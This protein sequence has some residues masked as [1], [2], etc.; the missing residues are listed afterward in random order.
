L[1]KQ[2]FFSIAEQVFAKNGL[3]DYW[4]NETKDKF[5]A[6]CNIILEQ[7]KVMN[8]SAIRDEEGVICRH[9]AD[10]LTVAKHI[11]AGASVLDVGSGGGI[12]QA[13]V[14]GSNGGGG[15]SYTSYSGM[16]APE[17]PEVPE[18]L[19]WFMASRYVCA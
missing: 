14:G 9:F 6:L 4:N 18:P 3:S 1:E 10:S 12:G 13:Q 2:E 19:L 5:Y 17:L 8:L 16:T 11:P 15:Y 7:N